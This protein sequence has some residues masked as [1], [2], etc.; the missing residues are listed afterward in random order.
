M[1]SGAPCSWTMLKR[2]FVT[3]LA[4]QVTSSELLTLLARPWSSCSL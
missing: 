2:S 3:T 4:V 1:E